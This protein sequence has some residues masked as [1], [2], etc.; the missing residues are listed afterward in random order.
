MATNDEQQDTKGYAEL[1]PAD[2]TQTE[3]ERS[4]RADRVY[5]RYSAAM[6]FFGETPSPKGKPDRD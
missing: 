3:A 4:E 1:G 2:L 6:E 5:A